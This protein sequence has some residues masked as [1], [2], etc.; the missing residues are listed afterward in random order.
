MWRGGTSSS[1]EDL[2]LAD[3]KFH[4]E[5]VA[6]VWEKWVER[7]TWLPSASCTRR[8]TWEVVGSDAV[9]GLPL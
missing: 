2:V 8:V 5:A 6:P 4:A 7:D 9:K 3:L 1:Q